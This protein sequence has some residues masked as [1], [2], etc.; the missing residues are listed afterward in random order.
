MKGMI[1]ARRCFIFYRYSDLPLFL[2]NTKVTSLTLTKSEP[3]LQDIFNV[4]TKVDYVGIPESGEQSLIR[5]DSVMRQMPMS[6][7]RLAKSLIG[8]RMLVEQRT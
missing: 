3:V 4:I 7:T 1:E 8:Q 5:S 2:A 6:G